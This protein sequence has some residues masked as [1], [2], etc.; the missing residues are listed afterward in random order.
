[1]HITFIREAK[2]AEKSTLRR[3]IR[4]FKHTSDSIISEKQVLDERFN[5]ISERVKSFSSVYEGK[6]V[7]FVSSSEDDNDH[8]ADDGSNDSDSNDWCFNS[9]QN[10]KNNDQRV[11]SC[12]YPSASEEMLR[13]GMKFEMDGQASPASVSLKGNEGKKSSGKKRK[14]EYQ[15]S[16]NPSIHKL[17]KTDKEKKSAQFLHKFVRKQI[18][19]QKSEK[20]LHS[21]GVSKD[22]SQSGDIENDDQ[23]DSYDVKL[24]SDDMG[25]FITTWKE[26]CREHTVGEVCPFS[27][28]IYFYIP[29]SS[30]LY[31]EM[32]APIL[33]DLYFLLVMEFIKKRM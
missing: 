32:D 30:M 16:S 11:S 4:A 21:I 17:S 7:R 23:E 33:I 15:S 31:L 12:P 5:S 9:S 24:S 19:F 8:D 2:K 28:N 13:L 3:H 22:E 26:T 14:A 1:M 27:S 10:K 6:H 20:N 29:F 18:L 25:K